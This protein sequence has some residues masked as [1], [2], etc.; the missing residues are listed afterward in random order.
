MDSE[1]RL[2]LVPFQME[3]K[4]KAERI[5][6]HLQKPR[7]SVASANRFY[8]EWMEPEWRPATK[9]P[10]PTVEKAPTEPRSKF[11]LFEEY[12]RELASG[13]RSA[14]R[15]EAEEFATFLRWVR[16]GRE[17]DLHLAEKLLFRK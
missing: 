17:D 10:Q 9:A 12:Q 6:T 8:E 15:N 11:R 7:A 4:A 16:N 13:A 5:Q 14:G 2:K 1:L 3:K